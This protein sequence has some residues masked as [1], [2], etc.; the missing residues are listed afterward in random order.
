MQ[1]PMRFTLTGCDFLR[2]ASLVGGALPEAAGKC[3][4]RR[5]WRT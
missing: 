3:K 4:L 5:S 1:R 2:L